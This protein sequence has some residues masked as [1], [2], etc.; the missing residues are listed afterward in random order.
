M[1]SGHVCL[2]LAIVSLEILEGACSLVDDL[3]ADA[4][5]VRQPPPEAVAVLDAELPADAGRNVGPAP[6]TLALGDYPV[7]ARRGT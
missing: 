2:L 3:R 1:L 5:V 4:V 6:R 7:A